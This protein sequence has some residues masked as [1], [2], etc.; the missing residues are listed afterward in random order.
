M[1]AKV[2]FDRKPFSR[3]DEVRVFPDIKADAADVLNIPAGQCYLCQKKNIKGYIPI[4][5]IDI[6]D[7]TKEIDWEQRR[8]EIAK[9]ILCAAFQTV[10]YC[11]DGN[12]MFFQAQGDTDENNIKK[13]VLIADRLINELKK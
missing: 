10:S 13:A 12:K 9:A 1:E 3:G 7:Y 11:T 2:K 4:T 5:E 8:Y 6:T